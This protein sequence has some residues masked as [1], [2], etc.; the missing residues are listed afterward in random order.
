MLQQQQMQQQQMQQQQM[1]QQQP[2]QQQLPIQQQLPMQ[3]QQ[4]QMQ[5]QLPMQY[6]HQTFTRAC[7]HSSVARGSKLRPAAID[8][9]ATFF[10]EELQIEVQGINAR[11]ARPLNAVRE[12][13]YDKWPDD[14][15]LVTVSVRR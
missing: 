6:L 13:L 7:L 2:M 15:T 3:Q 14:H 10:R 12:E 11:K 9:V 8:A 1:Q 4:M 5:Q